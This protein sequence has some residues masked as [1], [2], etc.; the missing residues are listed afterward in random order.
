[1]DKVEQVLVGLMILCVGALI[2]LQL[3]KSEA[4]HDHILYEDVMVLNESGEM[5]WAGRHRI[6][7]GRH[8][9]EMFHDKKETCGSRIES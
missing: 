7:D 4:K 1:M 8:C 3:G 9:F 2:G 6:K 5:F